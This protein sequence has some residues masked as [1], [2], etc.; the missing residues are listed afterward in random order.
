MFKLGDVIDVKQANNISPVALAFVGDAVYSLYVRE[1]LVF[2][3][4]YKTGELNKL[5]V[6][7]V[8]ATSQAQFIK[9]VMPILTEEELSVYKR[10]RNA[11][12]STKAK[13]ASV[14]E[15]N[16]STGFEALLGFLYVTGQHERL[17]FILEKG[18]NNEGWR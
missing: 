14:V 1:K 9:E 2:E 8:K 15:Y 5:A 6:K 18:Q 16:M 7:E 12:K 4:D 10:G 3:S 13:N 17:N 11:K